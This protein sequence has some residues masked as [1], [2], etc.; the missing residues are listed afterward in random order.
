[1]AETFRSV[2]RQR[3]VEKIYYIDGVRRSIYNKPEF[4]ICDTDLNILSDDIIGTCDIEIPLLEP[5]DK[6]F[7]HDINETVTIKERIR[8]SN[9]N[10]VYYCEDKLV[11]TEKT[12]ESF[13]KCQ[14]QLEKL[15]EMKIEID[16][17][18]KRIRE[19]EIYKT[20]YKYKHRWFNFKIQEDD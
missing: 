7:L 6:F 8:S 11:E 12:K 15:Y 13:E 9:G 5:D 14:L 19:L 17:L 10:I 18:R 20:Q 16:V 2:F 1:M 4:Y 3:K